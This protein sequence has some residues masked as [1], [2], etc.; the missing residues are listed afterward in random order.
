M[1]LRFQGAVLTLV[2]FKTCP[3]GGIIDGFRSCMRWFLR[4]NVES[5]NFAVIYN[6]FVGNF[7]HGYLCQVIVEIVLR[8]KDFGFLFKSPPESSLMQWD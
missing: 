5:Q 2:I 6:K 8:N 1:V 3:C 4:I 7:A